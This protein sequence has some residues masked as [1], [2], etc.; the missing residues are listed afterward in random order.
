MTALARFCCLSLAL[1]APAAALGQTPLQIATFQADVTPPIGS[2]LCNGGVA[3]AKTIDDPLS[4]RGVVLLGKDQPIVL[5]AVDWVGIANGSHDAWREALADAA[6]TTTDRVAVHCLHQHDAPGL[7]STAEEL[8]A[9]VGLG[10]RSFDAVFARLAMQRTATAVRESLPRARK[11]THVG[12]GQAVVDRVAS[13]RRVLGPDGMVK[14]V[15]YSSTTNPE[16]IAAPE[17]TIDPLLR[18]VSFWDGD[19][20]I[21][22]LTWY[23]THPQSHYGK[24]GV[25]ADIPGLARSRREAALPGPAHIHFNGASGNV[26][27]GKYNDGSPGRRPE[28]AA[29]LARGMESAW[30]SQQ[31]TAITAADVDW[32]V[33][34][35]VLPLR[36]RIRD[37]AAQLGILQNSAASS[38]D[39]TRAAR[40]L[41][42][43]QRMKAGRAI[44]I[45]CLKLGP[46]W[47]LHLPGELFVEYQLAAQAMRPDEFVAL[48]AYGDYGPGYIGTAIAYTQGGYETGVVSRTAPEVEDVLLG[49]MRKLLR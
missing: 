14:Y 23:A 6:G 20:P 13:N 7:D 21:A 43:A 12:F 42:F 31:K 27:A 32:R 25:S 1:T 41:S 24:G 39:R 2:P 36:D 19:Q 37:E 18:L 9:G 3:P 15:R 29:R 5:C 38:A 26:T 40:D 11:V 46:G 49:A 35:V 10:G 34:P 16:A 47:I 8:L 22:S 33:E 44:E 4:A 28:L 30:N 45:S 48:A 17:G